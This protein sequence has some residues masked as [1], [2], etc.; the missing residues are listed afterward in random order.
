MEYLF[1]V[2]LFLTIIISV[3]LVFITGYNKISET[4][5]KMDKAQSSIDELLLKK[6]SLMKD[7]YKL[8]KKHIKKKDYLKD[9]NEL[10]VDKMTT[11]ELDEELDKYFDTMKEIKDSYKSLNTKEYKKM[12]DSISEVSEN[13]I[14]NERF[15]N[16]YNNVLIKQLTGINKIIANFTNIKVK[17][18]Y[19]IKEP[20]AE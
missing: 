11:Y 3:V 20:I 18:S 6:H 10:K 9:F 1:I 15:F 16:K 5:F 17:T 12:L 8:I 4:S 2:V 19:D 14:A 13:I 7:C